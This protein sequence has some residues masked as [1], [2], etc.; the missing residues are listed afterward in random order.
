MFEFGLERLGEGVV[1]D[2]QKNLDQTWP[3]GQGRSSQ[4]S[5]SVL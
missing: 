2:Y 1:P 3:L 4:E 5:E